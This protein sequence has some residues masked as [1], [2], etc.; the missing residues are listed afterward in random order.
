MKLSELPSKLSIRKILETVESDGRYI[1]FLTTSTLGMA[2][3]AL[4]DEFGT[5]KDIDFI[6]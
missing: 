1:K 4:K 6:L 5:G 2:L 3:P